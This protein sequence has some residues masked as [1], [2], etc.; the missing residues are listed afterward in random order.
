[1]SKT[2]TMDPLYIIKADEADK[3]DEDVVEK[4][5]DE[6]ENEEEEDDEKEEKAGEGEG[7][8]EKGFCTI[9][10]SKGEGKKEKS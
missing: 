3:E 6:E 7:E 2:D 4:E 9:R 1:M 8:D 10:E 5:L